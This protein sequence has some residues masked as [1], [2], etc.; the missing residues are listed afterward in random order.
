M[1]NFYRI[2]A[3]FAC[4][5]A[6]TI[7]LRS[8]TGSWSPQFIPPTQPMLYDID[9]HP[10]GF[11]LAV[12]KSDINATTGAFYSG[13][14]M[15]LDFGINWAQVENMIPRFDP[16]LP[17]YA[18]WRA[19]FILNENVAVI[20]GD[21]GLVYRTKD[22][23]FSWTNDSVSFNPDFAARPTL[24]DVVLISE[25]V[26][27]IVGGDVLTALPLNSE[28]HP[29]QVFRT[30]DGKIWLDRS[31]SL[32]QTQNLSAG[33]NACAYSGG[34]L[35][36][37]GE[38]GM[39]LM[40]DGTGYQKLNIVSV[41]GVY[42]HR[43]TDID[44]IS[45]NEIFVVGYDEVFN[46]PLA[47]RSI[48]D[49]SRFSSIVPGNLAF[50]VRRIPAVDFLHPSYGWLGASQFYTGMTNDACA[51]WTTFNVPGTQVQ[52][53]MTAI[54]FTDELNGWACG[55]DEA[56]NTGWVIR[57]SGAPPKANI[58][59]SDTQVD[60]GTIECENSVEANVYI[61]NTG[62]GD[63]WLPMNSVFF[64]DPGL[65][66]ISPT[67]FPV[68]IKP[69][70]QAILR[71]RWTMGR[72][73]FGDAS[74][75]MTIWHNDPDH[76]P[77][78]VSLKVKRNY[79]AL[80]FMPEMQLS[81][82]TCLKDTVFFPTEVQAVGNRTPT[83][84][85]WKYVSGHNDF[86]ILSPNPGTPVPTSVTVNFRFAPS[87]TGMR[88][89]VYSLVHGNPI[90]PDTSLIVLTGFGQRTILRASVDTI[91]FGEV[92]A[93]GQKDTS[94]ILRSLGNTY[95]S[96]GLIEHVSGDPLFGSPD[97]GVFLKQDSAKTFRLYF[98]PFK[99]G[100]FNARYRIVSGPCADTLYLTFRG[101][102][103]ETKLEISPKG[104]IQLG[105][106]FVNRVTTKDVTITNIG[107][108][109]ARITEIRLLTTDPALQIMAPPALPRPLLPTQT[110][111]LTLRFAPNKLGEI[112]TR[113]LVRWDARCADTVDVEVNAICVPNPE[114][115][116]PQ[117]ADLGIQPCP[118]PLRDTVWIKNKGNGPLV[119]Y[120]SSVS[121]VD[122]QHFTII[123]PKINDTAKAMSDYPIIVEFNRPDPGRSHAIIRFTHNDIDAGRT[124]IDVT[125]ERTVAHFV[126]EGDSS[127]AF[128]TRL[129]VEESRMFIV[130]N[131][132]LQPM[133][134]TDIT[135]VEE[136]TV[137]RTDL[138][139]D[140][141]ISLPPGDTMTF[142]V[143]FTPDARGPFNGIVQITGTPCEYSIALGLTGSGDTDGLS[144]DR[145]NLAF[146]LDPCSYSSA[147]QNIVLKNQ[148]PEAVLV[149][150]LIIVQSGTVFSIDPSISTPFNIGPNG[151]RTVR[152]CASP[153]A[154]GSRTGTLQIH[155]NDP[156]YPLLNVALT[157]KRDSSGIT[158]GLTN[159]DFGR[160]RLCQNVPT[161]RV[162]ITNTGTL[163]ETV[164]PALLNG[165]TA[166]S[167]SMSGPETIQP[168][169]TYIVDVNY[170]RSSFG[171]H[172]D[173][174]ELRT[175]RCQ[176]VFRI[177][178]QGEHVEQTYVAAPNPVVFPTVNVGGVATRQLTLQNNG[179]FQAQIQAWWST[180]S[181]PFSASGGFGVSFD[182]G[183]T[184][185]ITLQ[186]RPTTEGTFST[187]FCMVIQA[188]CPD[189]ICVTLQGEAVKGTLEL[190]PAL[191]AFKTLAQCEDEI[192]HD[193]LINTGS[194]PITLLSASING[195]GQAAFTNLTPV[196]GGG[197]VLPPSGVRIFSI[198]YNA[199]NAP[200]DG[201]VNAN[202]QIRT[203]DNVLP[204]FDIPLEAGRVTQRVD[205]GGV[206]DFGIVEVGQPEQRTV[207]LRNTGSVRL[208]YE[209]LS[210]PSQVV[211]TP[212]L[213]I[214]IDPGRTVDITLTY[215]AAAPGSFSGALVLRVPTPCTDSTMFQLSAT[216]QEGML[217]QTDTVRL[218]PAPWCDAASFSFTARSTYLETVSLT[219]MRLEGADAAFFSI[220]SP[221][222]SSL[223]RSI[224]TGGTEQFVV[225]L[226]PDQR[227][228]VF[229]AS[230]VA[231]YTAFGQ[232]MQRRTVVIAEA[233][234]PSLSVEG[235]TFPAT[236]LGQSA[237]TQTLRI[238][239]TSTL[240]LNV[241]QLLVADPSFVVRS[242]T[243]TP[244]ATLQ[245]NGE[246]TVTI[247]FIP[248]VTGQL[249]DSLVVVSQL[250]CAFRANGLLNGEGIPQPIVEA[251]ITIG[252]I[253]G[254][255]DQVVDIPIS[256]DKSLA[257]AD[258]GGWSAALTFNRS[259]L[260]PIALITEGTPSA[261]LTPSLSWD[262]ANS[263]ATFGATA[264]GVLMSAGT[265]PIAWLR[266]RVLVGDAQTTALTLTNFSFTSGYARMSGRVN[267][268]FE[269]L[270]YCMPDDRLLRDRAGFSISQSIPNPVSQTGHG[271]ASLSFVLPTEERV[272]LL[273]FDQIG[274]QVR[275]QDFGVLP[276]GT[277]STFLAVGDLRP[278][279]YHYVLRTT[280]HTAI[281]SMVV[282]E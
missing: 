87:D 71:V 236:V 217:V 79:G 255:V 148:A 120:S 143:I 66:V 145:G 205:A 259:M 225:E 247:E 30:D 123:Q 57:F 64:T 263:I 25:R 138:T 45:N 128:F 102:G 265:G 47:Y 166:F 198:R 43:Y 229:M 256:V 208:C 52:S 68:V 81:Y 214:C 206:I 107:T 117:S 268:S 112:R 136:A 254:E 224:A 250:P 40:D 238:R 207:T 80:N 21:S 20:V 160:S 46:T 274:R 216:S 222:P 104:P 248:Q 180:P 76:N 93:G 31:P 275:E 257:G 11:G 188:N 72:N 91:D 95:V 252:D 99:A 197:E 153:E 65:K 190:H 126:L 202:L 3:V 241:S 59:V 282:I 41:P 272:T 191:L 280:Q 281:R 262:Y 200:A 196:P 171:I 157:S 187:T 158:V 23:G 9:M 137:Y 132:S 61:R 17:D 223:P 103:I 199:A 113:L 119:F 150:S 277:H 147:C 211:M 251:T 162:A 152:I 240:P 174:L 12:G 159:I 141:P 244:P 75:T 133:S 155:S 109:N 172:N 42:R 135:V 235:A 37:A 51:S 154:I 88:R 237:G 215:S 89:G 7:P 32:Q 5:I 164:T 67:V 124:D 228:K 29:N 146:T 90:C 18:L 163:A 13:V 98:S 24:R 232:P 22:G 264:S 130:R 77:W 86:V 70:K 181:G 10:S 127:T 175:T 243:P 38:L 134:V 177:P 69:G 260:Y 144:T 63:L 74:A 258:V 213:P 125:A 62:T 116:A 189:T 245:P 100:S 44:A 142:K 101:R 49:L 192:L 26:G 212:S 186:F 246:M 210:L 54:D 110:L 195:P 35:F 270:N 115:E 221:T 118:Q 156:A 269:L 170:L 50:G 219:G 273:I 19:V 234:V 249:R 39:L 226:N 8:Q 193:T 106:I 82:G 233:V 242:Q 266:C 73:V 48:R 151:E 85:S 131:T 94:I 60:F 230:F 185:N 201:A 271:R 4:L 96:G 218:A 58:S 56:A 53:Y 209:T 33:L 15:T 78:T 278:G 183:G 16:E 1:A 34:T 108:T 167:I 165:G 6:L 97:W 204:Q 121:G 276:A 173:I 184:V 92:C 161:Y 194:G 179:G 169:K 84:I 2:L 231:E 105:P 27:Y 253:S 129:F 111:G 168:G 176:S 36:I 239:N 140:L 261:A 178:M 55:G 14:L 227:N 139:R 83:F 182:P 114:I 267:G 149:N 28:V 279:V 220:L 122:R 203:D